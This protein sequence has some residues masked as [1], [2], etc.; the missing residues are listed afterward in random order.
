MTSF[1]DT[2]GS[3]TGGGYDVGD[4]AM[5]NKAGKLKPTEKE[6][7]SCQ[8]CRKLICEPMQLITCGCRYCKYCLNCIMA[9]S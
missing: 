1:S 5:Y 4:A 3:F 2:A 6:M 9:E 7:L 8:L